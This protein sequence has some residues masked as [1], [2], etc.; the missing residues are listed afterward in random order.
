M[1]DYQKRDEIL[2][3][4][5]Y[6]SY[7]SYLKSSLWKDIRKKVLSKYEVCAACQIKP[8]TQIHHQEYTK[9]V[10]AGES[11]SGLVGVCGRCH[12][13]MEFTCGKKN[14]LKQAN[15]K[16]R[17]IRLSSKK[18]I[19]KEQKRKDLGLPKSKKESKKERRKRLKEQDLPYIHKFTCLQCKQNR[20]AQVENAKYCSKCRQITQS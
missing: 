13:K 10:L 9:D 18:R 6:S 4:L 15:I 11:L 5:G 14:T 8:S 1:S 17:K 16:F 7:R 20:F 19:L 2:S 12:V 3:E